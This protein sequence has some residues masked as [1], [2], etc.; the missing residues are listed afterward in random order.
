MQQGQIQNGD[1]TKTR[2]GRRTQTLC[3]GGGAEHTSTNF[4]NHSVNSV[5]HACSPP[6]HLHYNNNFTAIADKGASHHYCHTNAPVPNRDYNAPTTVVGIVDGNYCKSIA[7]ATLD[8]PD[9]PPGT[10]SCHIMPSF[11]NNLLSM[12]VFCDADCSVTFTKHNARV[13]NNAGTVILTGFRE[14]TGAKMW[15]FNLQPPWHPCHPPPLACNAW[16]PQIHQS[17][18]IPDDDEDTVQQYFPPASPSV[19]AY[20][21]AVPP[22]VHPIVPPTIH[23]PAV[24]TPSGTPIMRPTEYHRKAYDL[25]STRALIEYLHCC[26][27]SPK[28]STL[29]KAVKNGNFRSFPGLTY[30]NVSRYCPDNANATVLGHLTQVRQGLRST[31]NPTF[32]T[33]AYAGAAYSARH[34]SNDE[35]LHA[36]DLIPNIALYCWEE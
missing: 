30:T 9:L 25:P 14:P 31:A 21:P 32:H 22:T 20:L 17:H 12:G 7:T 24:R 6:N 26:I 1:A 36:M 23:G 11:V 27:G 8:L 15:W 16:P 34:P 3:D 29:L 4:T 10:A 28:K 13:T 2:A 33:A 5:T 35:I 18:I 19:P